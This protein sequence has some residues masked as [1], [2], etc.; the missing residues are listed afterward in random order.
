M[1]HPQDRRF[2]VVVVGAGVA[3]SL[4]AAG[5]MDH[6]Q[7]DLVCLERVGRDDH[8]E[9]GTGLNIGPNAIMCLRAHLPEIAATLE[10]NSLPWRRWTI[11]LT[12]GHPLMD[13]DLSEVADNPGIRIRWSELYALLRS[14]LADHIVYG[15]ELLE[16]R[17]DHEGVF[18]RWR[19]RDGGRERE[20]GGIDL[21]IGGDGR[22][23]LV[24]QSFFG[25]D[26]ATFLGVCLYRLLFS[27]GPDCPVDEY[28]QWF[29]GPNRLLAFRVPGDFIYCAGSFP[30]PPDSQVPDAMKAA[31]F[32]RDL[33]TP[34]DGA[35]SPEAAFLVAAIERHCDQ[36]HWARLQEGSIR[37]AG[38]SAGVLLVGDA[39]HP[40]V[41]TLGQGATQAVEDACVVV[42]EI[43]TAL[44]AGAGL[45]KVPQRVAQV[46]EGRIK[47]VMELSRDAT[48]TM[49]AG[50]DPVAGTLKK[51][52]PEFRD[53]LAALYRDVPL[54]VSA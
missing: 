22:Y 44:A 45:G 17:R 2:R 9:A 34:D 16:T 43:H 13:L 5:L 41:P 37:L 8:S 53:K 21:L 32:L 36:I 35:L 50:A 49:L 14:P 52:K 30:I 20:L 54:P 38:D 51:L 29:N 24:R 11:S 19:E 7:V 46:R 1:S 25:E 39:A 40:M 33:Y 6:P 23:S 26:S 28:G 27:A 10:R 12:S 3:G 48:D 31:A 42:Q 4:I 15:A 18:V 47:F